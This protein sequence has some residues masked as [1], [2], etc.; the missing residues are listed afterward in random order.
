MLQGVHAETIAFETYADARGLLLDRGWPWIGSPSEFGGREVKLAGT[1]PRR[2]RLRLTDQRE[3]GRTVSCQL[4][5][6]DAE[7]LHAPLMKLELGFAPD[8]KNTRI[9]LRGSTSRDLVPATV[10]S[11]ADPR[12]PANAY[13]RA[14]LD[15]L[16]KAMEVGSVKG[17]S[18]RKR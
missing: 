13:A 3:T 9:R 4:E 6:L 10:T 5:L 12:G 8:G 17:L 2:F 7:R 11:G 15:Q 14:L 1:R 16:A 18:S